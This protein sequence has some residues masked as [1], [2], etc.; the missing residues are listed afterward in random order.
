MGT[1]LEA[2]TGIYQTLITYP[3]FAVLKWFRLPAA[4]VVIE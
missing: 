2:G 4:E 3:A 1:P